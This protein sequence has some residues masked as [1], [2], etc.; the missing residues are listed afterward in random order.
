MSYVVP[1]MKR[2]GGVG[3][4][5]LARTYAV[6]AAR[7]GASVLIADLDEGQSTSKR[8]ADHRRQNGLKP[9]IRAEIST[10]RRAYDLA[11]KADVLVIDTPPG[12]TEKQTLF[13]ARWSTFC[14]LPSGANRLDDLS[15]TV[16]LI[17]ALRRGGLEPWRY[18]VALNALRSATAKQ[19]DADARAY[20]AEVG[21]KA[22]PG[23]TRDLRAYEIAML[24]GRAITETGQKALNEEAHALMNGIAGA[25]LEAGRQLTRD[26]GP[27]KGPSREGPGHER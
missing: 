11:G 3:A 22:L 12:W 10:P 18:G 8:W 2:K 25:V 27:A 15:E 16:R 23:Y 6:E 13:V 7:A 5:T 21:F 24:E 14:V 1:F 17:Y 26:L 9:E 4:S 19:D 20:L